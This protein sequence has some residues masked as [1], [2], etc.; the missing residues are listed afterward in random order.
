MQ[1]DK[2]VGRMDL[3]TDDARPRVLP[4]R[5]DST[6]TRTEDTV[7]DFARVYGNGAAVAND[8]EHTLAEAI[9]A[10]PARAAP[11][12]CSWCCGNYSA[13][14]QRNPRLERLL[15]SGTIGFGSLGVGG[16][17]RAA[18]D[19]NYCGANFIPVRIKKVRRAGDKPGYC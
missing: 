3:K 18:R 8:H 7:A 4:L 5:A 2:S 13:L 15:L 17:A 12:A 9:A 14:R 10:A 19:P 16:R 1:P 11:R 6:V